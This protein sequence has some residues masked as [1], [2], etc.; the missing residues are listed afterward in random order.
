MPTKPWYICAANATDRTECWSCCWWSYS[1]TKKWNNTAIKWCVKNCGFEETRK[2]VANSAGIYYHW[3]I[4][5]PM[6]TIA[7][8]IGILFF[9]YYYWIWPYFVLFQP[10]VYFEGNFISFQINPLSANRTKWSNTLEQFVGN[11]PTNCLS[12]FDH[13]LG[14]A[15]KG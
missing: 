11:L 9:P 10:F 2:S 12:V 7:K 4:F 13:Y 15:L 5:L 14:L 1:V 3:Y 8:F 6:R